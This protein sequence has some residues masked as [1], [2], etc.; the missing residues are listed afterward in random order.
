MIKADSMMSAM[1]GHEGFHQALL[2]F[3]QD[4]LIKPDEG[5]LPVLSKKALEAE[6]AGVPDTKGI[7]WKPFKAEAAR[8]GELGYTFGIWKMVTHDT[9]YY[10]NYYTAWKKGEDG[11]WKW[12][13]D[14]G[15]N[16]PVPKWTF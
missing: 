13:V 6:W 2:S 12:V 5:K 9:T 10:G 4:S 11:L 1:A 15:N 7:S 8:S 3:A 16:T 14:G